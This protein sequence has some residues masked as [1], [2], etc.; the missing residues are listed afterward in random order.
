MKLQWNLQQ[1]GYVTLVVALLIPYLV[2]WMPKRVE[3]FKHFSIEDSDLIAWIQ[4]IDPSVGSRGGSGSS[5]GSFGY[6]G[7]KANADMMS[8]MEYTYEM[9]AATPSDVFFHLVRR[10]GGKIEAD[11]WRISES[12]S[13]RGLCSFV[14]S[15]GS[16]CYRV[17][18][19]DL[20][21]SRDRIIFTE[22]KAVQI[23]IL[24]IGYFAG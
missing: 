15:H 13:T 24:T 12:E 11:G 22:E 4:E 9:K 7:G 10:I 19:I 8:E 6:S 18:I 23:K 21:P 16:T 17:Y 2:S 14:F 5:S 20:P 1:L 3:Q